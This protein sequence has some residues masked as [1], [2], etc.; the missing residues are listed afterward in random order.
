MP[1]RRDRP[2]I[3]SSAEG[4]CLPDRRAR[5]PFGRARPPAS[6][7]R[8]RHAG[9]F[10]GAARRPRKPR[11][12]APAIRSA[13]AWRVRPVRRARGCRPGFPGPRPMPSVARPTS[14]TASWRC[15][16][17]R[18]PADRDATTGPGWVAAGAPETGGKA[19][20][21]TAPVARGLPIPW[22]KP[23]SAT[24]DSYPHCLGAHADPSVYFWPNV[25]LTA[26]TGP[27]RPP[28]QPATPRH[29]HP[30]LRRRRAACG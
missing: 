28:H 29:R 13:A 18:N 8:R 1:S 20:R 22:G 23:I 24:P 9:R 12:P 27:H 21:D 3:G 26:A 19:S 15:T 14:C 16:R 4:A 30:E 7:R 5:R 25:G 2:V 11:A 6:R 17:D 10:A